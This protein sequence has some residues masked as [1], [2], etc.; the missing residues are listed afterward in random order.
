LPFSAV[1]LR[2]RGG[3]TSCGS[4]RPS[5]FPGACKSRSRHDR[6]RSAEDALRPR[7]LVGENGSSQSLQPIHEEA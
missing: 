6:L 2:V 4:S 1:I 5:R 3:Y 7:F